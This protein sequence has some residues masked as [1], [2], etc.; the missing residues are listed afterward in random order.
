MRHKRSRKAAQYIKLAAAGRFGQP[1]RPRSKSTLTRAMAAS[2]L[3][4]LNYMIYIH[5]TEFDQSAFAAHATQHLDLNLFCAIHQSNV[6]L[7][8]KILDRQLVE[9][10][11]KIVA[12]QYLPGSEAIAP[13][14]CWTRSITL[15]FGD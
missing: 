5:F 1:K 12:V 15:F 3:G 6:V 9:C 14:D 7:F 13:K 8:K 2:G 4:F 10:K 11:I